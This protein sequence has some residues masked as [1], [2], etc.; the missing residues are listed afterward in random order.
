MA[1]TVFTCTYRYMSCN[2]GVVSTVRLSETVNRGYESLRT[3]V[4]AYAGAEHCLHPRLVCSHK[5]S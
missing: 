2:C 1:G 5:S 3:R 4:A